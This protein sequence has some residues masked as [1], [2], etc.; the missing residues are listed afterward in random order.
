MDG[1]DPAYGAFGRLT[2]YLCLARVDSFDYAQDDTGNY[3]LDEKKN[4]VPSGLLNISLLDRS[5][6]R[7]KVPFVLPMA[8]NSVFVGGLPEIGS[9]CI[10]GWR[11]QASPVIIGFL[12]YGIGNVITQRGTTPS[13]QAGEVLLQ[14]SNLDF[15]ANGSAENYRGAKVFL[16]RYGRINISTTGYELIVGYLLSD[17][18][19]PVVTALK[20]PISGQPIYLRERLPGGT[21]RVVDGAG[22]VTLNYGKDLTEAVSGN[23]TTTV[24]GTLVQTAKGQKL[25]DLNGNTFELQDDGSVLIQSATGT[26]SIVSTAHIE[27]ESNANIETRSLGDRTEFVGGEYSQTAA[28]KSDV[29]ILGLP[30]TTSDSKKVVL[31]NSSESIL[32]GTKTIAASM[33]IALEAPAGGISFASTMPLKLGS[34][35]ASN[36]TIRGP[37]LIAALTVLSAALR[38][39]IGVTDSVSHITTASP[40]LVKALDSFDSVLSSATNIHVLT[41]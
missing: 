23:V 3:I 36:F 39:T 14:S 30:L 15:D 25:Q 8:G 16:D 38:G 40:V 28:V 27:L 21:E 17:E 12:P 5:G 31:G 35:S 20:D 29:T 9:L 26:V 2:S 10:V 33:G 34:S 19:T 18:N 13:I 7:D 24:S 22:S 1:F 32:A 6:S 41:D 37:Q 4:Q 11:Q